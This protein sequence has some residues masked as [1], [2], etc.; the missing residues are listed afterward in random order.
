MD[1]A[2]LAKQFGGSVVQQPQQPQQH[3]Q[4]ATPDWM[5]GLSPKDQAELQ[6]KMHS[7]GR[8]RIAELD[9]SISNSSRTV[10]MLNRFGQLNRNS[11]TGDIHERLFPTFD[12]MRGDDEK[13]MIAIQNQLAPKMRETGSGASS[14][15]DVSMFLSSLPGIDKPGNVNKNIRENFQGQY[16]NAVAKRTAMES[17]LHNNG[18][19]VGFDDQWSKRGKPA[20]AQSFSL[21]PN[22]KQFAGKII[23]DTQTNKKFKS[24]GTKWVPQ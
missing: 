23:T 11:R 19:L 15:R 17:Y 21:P 3:Q 22:A 1:Y 8:K 16:N 14:D 7:E 20:A 24:D 10:D 6:M 2:S 13:E 18:T 5:G 12:A 9:E 4:P